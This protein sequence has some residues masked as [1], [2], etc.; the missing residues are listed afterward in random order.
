MGRIPIVIIGGGTGT[1]VLLQGLRSFSVDP[2]VIVGTS[3]NGGS[4]GRL[5]EELGILPVGDIRQCVLAMG[6][7]S[8]MERALWR[9]RFTK[10]SVDGHCVGNVLLA[11]LFSSAPNVAS[12]LERI[13]KLWK[14]S[15]SIVPMTDVA[16]TLCARYSDGM[17][18]TG[19]HAIDEPEKL[20]GG[21]ERVYLKEKVRF[22]ANAAVALRR[23]KF[24]VI[25]PGDLYTS[26]L[27]PLLPIGATAAVAKSRASIILVA[28]LMSKR[29]QTDGFT[30]SRL[31]SEVDQYLAPRSVA[32][33]VVY[34]TPIPAAIIRQHQT[35]GEHP[36]IPDAEHLSLRGKRL[37]RAAVLAPFMRERVAGDRLR[38]SLVHHDPQKLARV[39]MKILKQA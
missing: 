12:A 3:D 11:S 17:V 31:V 20:H 23:A 30:L 18:I 7:F 8:E 36:I 32:V 1:S 37:V 13:H 16:T 25:A 22:S 34:T 14:L 38:R 10:G 28:S 4:G 29:G 5:R 15:G 6:A 26:A 24:I 2:T 39:L 35:L 9:H 33:V 21:I 19:E 27:P